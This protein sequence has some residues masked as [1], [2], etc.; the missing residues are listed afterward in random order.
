MTVQIPENWADVKGKLLDSYPSKV[1]EGFVTLEVKAS[2]VKGV[3]G[4][5]NFLEDKK[6]EV[7]YVN[8]PEALA[9][10]MELKPGAKVSCRVRVAGQTRKLFAHPERVKVE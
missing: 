4:F 5:K 3:E 6:E 2:G 9:Q 10:S 7:I 1:A 8:V